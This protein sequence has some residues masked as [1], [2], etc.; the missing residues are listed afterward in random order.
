MANS[1]SLTVIRARGR[2]L[3]KLIH[4]DGSVEGY[5]SAKHFDLF[6]IPVVDLAA[7]YGLLHRLQERPDCAVVRGV[8]IDP[9]RRVNVRRLAFTDKHTGDLPTLRATPH[10][11]V[12]LDL[13]GLPKPETV[14]TE[15]LLGCASVAVQQLPDAFRAARCIVQASGSHGVKPGCRLRL[16]YW[17]NRPATDTEL[18]RWLRGVPTDPSVFRTVQPIYTAAPVFECGA[19]DHLPVRLAMLSGAELVAVPPPEILSPPPLWP[20][21]PMPQPSDTRAARYASAAL[22][23]AASRI[24]VAGVGHRHDRIL[25]EARGLARFIAAG[26]LTARTVSE[27]LM[28]AGCAAG[29]PKDEIAAVIEWA[30]AH[31]SVTALPESVVP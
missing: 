1:D 13:D 7:L 31:P 5:D 21:A 15:D 2:R 19:R 10:E 29:K 22:R 9:D 18:K 16:W 11:W 27:A 24:L 23:N 3:A 12:A 26:L 8:P 28:S 30:I 17:L 20:P 14:P 25:Q 4:E 6:V